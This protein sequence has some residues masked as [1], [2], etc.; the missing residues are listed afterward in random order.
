M[1]LRRLAGALALAL[2]AGV[3]C[4]PDEPGT[5]EATTNLEVISWWTS[6]SEE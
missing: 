5:N 6:G 2:V 4:A 1:K 3:A